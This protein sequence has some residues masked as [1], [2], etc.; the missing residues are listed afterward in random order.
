MERKCLNCNHLLAKKDKYCNNC[1]QKTAIKALNFWTIISDFFSNL[2]NVEAKIW[3]TFKDIW[4]PARLTI[5]YI[6][7]K[8]VMYYNPIRIFI[9]SLFTFFALY[10]FNI[11]NYIDKVDNVMEQ[12]EYETWKDDLEIKYD[13]LSQSYE[14]DSNKSENFKSELFAS[15]DSS[16]ITVFDSSIV[17]VYDTPD[18]IEVESAIT[19]DLDS[20]S[21]KE[22]TGVELN[23][24][25]GLVVSNFTLGNTE[26]IPGVPTKDIFMM[27]SEELK[28]KYRSKSSFNKLILLQLQK[29]VKNLGSSIQFFLGNGTWV[30]VVLILLTA[31]FFKLLYWRHHYL[32]AEH[33]IFHV[34]GHTRLLILAI[35]GLSTQMLF[36]DSSLWF[37]FCLFAGTVYLFLSMRTFYKQS[38]VKTF[39]KFSLCVMVYTFLL[40]IC[41]ILVLGLSFI[42]I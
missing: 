25:D 12:Q 35:I 24:E 37:L 21:E 15:L 40:N 31:W 34:Y 36:F 2:F 29:V 39:M 33:F 18:S 32:Y 38:F 26:I 14:L 11:K 16:I 30:I 7:G 42:M 8:R 17:T 1:G 22:F 3:R 5:A 4:V 27:S 9:V 20:L 41:A 23:T 19:E 6:S 10:L 28:E 13:S